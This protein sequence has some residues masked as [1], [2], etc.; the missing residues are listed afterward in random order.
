MAT[1][2]DTQTK[3]K[4]VDAEGAEQAAAAPGRRSSSS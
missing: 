3:P 2:N 4:D 1:K